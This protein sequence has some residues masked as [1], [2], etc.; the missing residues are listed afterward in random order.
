MRVAIAQV[1]CVLADVTANLEVA[2]ARVLEAAAQG[3]DL[4]VFPE[5]SL[6]GYAQGAAPADTSLAADDPR[7]LE[8]ATH[9]PDVLVGLYERDGRARH[10]SAAYLSQGQL[11]HLHRKLYLPHY[12]DWTERDHF[13]P[14]DR[15]AAFDSAH[16]RT[17]TLVCNDAW[18]PALPWLAAH[19]GAGLLLVPANSA[20]V[21]DGE[22]DNTAYW[23][24]LV[25]H[26]A[27]MQQCWVVFVNRVGTE[28]GVDFWGGSQI[29]AP[30]GAVVAQAP[31][32]EAALVVADVDVAEADRHRAALPLLGDPRFD[33]VRDH[34]PPVVAAT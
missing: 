21:N 34:L 10:N 22:L 31:V 32:G 30:G 23:H 33:L 12:R 29:L 26:I 13:S 25:R 11:L 1:D 27:R 6:H 28:N 9:G 7:V 14:G 5:L 2:R 4:V 15:L 24:D 3:A 8:L 16:A 19:D 18:Q 17:A 20:A